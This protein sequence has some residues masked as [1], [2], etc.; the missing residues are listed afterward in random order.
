[1]DSSAAR[2]A[3]MSSCISPAFRPADSAACKK[4]SKSSSTWSKAPRAGKLRTSKASNP[5][6][7]QVTNK[8]ARNGRLQFFCALSRLLLHVVDQHDVRIGMSAD[9]SQLR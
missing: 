1:M 9:Q 6:R 7:K 3:R 8:A 4:V 5:L 2:T